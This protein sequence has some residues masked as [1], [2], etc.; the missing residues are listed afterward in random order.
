MEVLIWLILPFLRSASPLHNSPDLP[1]GFKVPNI[2]EGEAWGGG[3]IE[4]LPVVFFVTMGLHLICP[5]NETF[6]RLA[7]NVVQGTRY[8]NAYAVYEPESDESSWPFLKKNGDSTWRQ[9]MGGP[10][11]VRRSRSP[12][13]WRKRPCHCGGVHE[14]IEFGSGFVCCLRGHTVS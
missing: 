8:T 9:E 1:V 2:G 13:R 4:W 5:K 10:L 6:E 3:I 11:P 12:V 14:G 7:L